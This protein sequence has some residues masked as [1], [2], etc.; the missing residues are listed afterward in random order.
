M[1]G[2]LTDSLC[3]IGLLYLILHV[4]CSIGSLREGIA[5]SIGSPTRTLGQLR[6]HL[7]N[8]HERPIVGANVEPQTLSGHRKPQ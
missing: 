7:K 6:P 4:R 3:I 5:G 2:I 1:D 8:P